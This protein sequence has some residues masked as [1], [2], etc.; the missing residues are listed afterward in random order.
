MT[1]LSWIFLGLAIIALVFYLMRR[2]SGSRT[3]R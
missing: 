1:P 2:S 3:R